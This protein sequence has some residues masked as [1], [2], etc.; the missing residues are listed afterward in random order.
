VAQQVLET[1][2]GP[3]A[4]LVARLDALLGALDRLFLVA[5]N[6]CLLL[7][8]LGTAATIV[9]RPV[10][11]SFYW[12]WPWTMQCFVWMSFIGFYVVYRRGKDITVDFVVQ[13]MGDRAMGLSRWFVGLVIL[14]VTG[15]ILWQT[16]TILSSQVGPI[17]GVMTPWGVE[18]ERYTLSVPLFVSCGLIWLNTLLD[19]AKAWLGQPEANPPHWV[20]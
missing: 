13:R 14:A 16:P 7:M 1:R 8:L 10:N 18:L 9:L 20:T 19:L 2:G 15:V 12:I 11:L 6:L 3:F 5:A 17:D 4:L